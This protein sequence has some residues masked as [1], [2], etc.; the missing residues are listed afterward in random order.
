MND[1]TIKWFDA[2]LQNTISRMMEDRNEKQALIFSRAFRY[3]RLEAVLSM[4]PISEWSKDERM[5]ILQKAATIRLV[6]I[7][8]MEKRALSSDIPMIERMP[9]RNIHAGLILKWLGDDESD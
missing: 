4:M 6:T 5:I 2:V 8:M 1:S 3:V 9:A 7:K